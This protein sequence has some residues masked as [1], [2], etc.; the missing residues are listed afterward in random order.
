MRQ[1]THP[2]FLAAVEQVIPAAREN[3]KYSGIN[4]MSAVEALEPWRTKGMTL[5]L[6]ANEVVLMMSAARRGLA[7]FKSKAPQ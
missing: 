6:W 3:G 7:R 5:K 4:T 2:D 1:L